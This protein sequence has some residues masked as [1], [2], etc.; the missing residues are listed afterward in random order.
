MIGNCIYEPK[1]KRVA[2]SHPLYE[3]FKTWV[4]INNLKIEPPKDIDKVTYLQE[5]IYPLFYKTSDFEMKTIF[6]QLKKMEQ[7]FIQDL[8]RKIKFLLQSC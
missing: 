8:K 7:R 4:F 1:K 5:S 3:E 2:I 6:N